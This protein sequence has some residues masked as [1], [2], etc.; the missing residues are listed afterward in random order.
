MIAFNNNGGNTIK[1]CVTPKFDLHL[2]QILTRESSIYRKNT[3]VHSHE[4]GYRY[5]REDLL[6]STNASTR[7]L[8]K[9][10]LLFG[11]AQ[12]MCDLCETWT[13]TN[14]Q[15]VGCTIQPVV[16]VR[17]TYAMSSQNTQLEPATVT[18]QECRTR[19]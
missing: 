2:R 7:E 8:P 11:T 9:D 10:G 14:C 6:P 18:V 16:I 15:G 19:F 1:K 3:R 13:G 12:Q 5:A 4:D 17:W